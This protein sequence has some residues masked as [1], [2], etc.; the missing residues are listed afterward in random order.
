MR[1]AII[2]Y[3]KM[4]HIIEEVIKER[5]HQVSVI[6]DAH[7]QEAF[8]TPA[9]LESDVAIEF[10]TPATAFDNVCKCLERGVPVVCG[11][12]GWTAHLPEAEDMCRR[13]DGAMMFASNY[14]IGVNIFMALSRYLTR[15]MNNF[16]EYH[17]GMV[18][19]HHVHK[20]D[21]PSG[22]AVTLADQLIAESTRMTNWA[23]PQAG[24]R[25]TDD[26][27]IVDHER[28]GEVPGIHTVTWTSQADEIS[29]THS[30]HSRRGFAVGA[31]MAAEWL[32]AH[33]GVQSIAD[34]MADITGT[35]GIF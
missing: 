26:T 7:N 5:G 10:T 33:P 32:P 8:D 13:M 15:V 3:G 20:L 34:M 27:L 6:I 16:P 12:T 9:F 11:S 30:A 4:G 18:E 21:H 23:E 28:R 31:V 1:F 29:I 14:S 25:P 2:G 17:P 35:K 19:V 24:V 22:T